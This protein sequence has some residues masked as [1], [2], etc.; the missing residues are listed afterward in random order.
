ML[1]FEE[2]YR[3]AHGGEAPMEEVEVSELTLLELRDYLE[4]LE[5]RRRDMDAAEPE[6]ETDE[7]YTDWAEEHEA[8][9]DLIDEVMERIEELEK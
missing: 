4:M 6:D 5:E 3:A 8:L 9:E 1:S 7:A 2:F